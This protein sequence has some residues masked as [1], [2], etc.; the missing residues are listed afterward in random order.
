MGEGYGPPL[1]WGQEN[2]LR[3]WRRRQ[4]GRWVS[5]PEQPEEKAAG[6]GVTRPEQTEDKAAAR[7]DGSTEESQGSASGGGVAATDR[8]GSVRA[9]AL[10]PGVEGKWAGGHRRQT[11]AAE[12]AAKSCVSGSKGRVI[13]TVRQDGGPRASQAGRPGNKRPWMER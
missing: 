11:G 2:S 7:L 12:A 9:V 8:V 4:L 10:G 13:S 5:H 6:Q 1:S 3:G